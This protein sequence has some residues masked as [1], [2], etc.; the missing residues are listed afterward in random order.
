MAVAPT[1]SLSCM[2]LGRAPA[3]R[4]K[5][6]LRSLNGRQMKKRCFDRSNER[7]AGENT[8]PPPHP[9]IF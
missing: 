9:K 5:E 3:D 8:L 1:E 7:Y 4:T 6:H 2:R